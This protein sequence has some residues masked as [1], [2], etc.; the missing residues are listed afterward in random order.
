[1]TSITL[2]RPSPRKPQHKQWI[3]ADISRLDKPLL[4]VNIDTEEEFDWTKPF[5]RD[6]TSVRSVKYLHRAQ[7]I[8]KSYGVKPCYLIDYPI[9]A[10]PYA[11]EVLQLWADEGDCLVGAQLHPWVTPPHE[12]VVCPY[13]SYPCNLP[14][15]LERRKIRILTETIEASVGVRPTIYKA[16]RYGIKLK[17]I[18]A[19]A[20]EGYEVDTSVVPYKSYAGLGGG[21]DFFGYPDQPFWPDADETRVMCLP[22]TQSLVGVMR[23]A[24]RR[25]LGRVVFGRD[26]IKFRLPGLFSR[27]GLLERIMLSPEGVSVD[28]MR[29]LVDGMID[30]GKRVFALSFHSPS[31]QTG[32]TPYVRS[33]EELS[34]FL[35]RIEAMIDYILTDKG[36]APATPL[37]IKTVLS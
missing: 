34:E 26:G 3:A 37:E 17:R 13:N 28:A 30:D 18:W 31:L 22:V 10:D 12:E 20:E 25:G 24:G 16:G 11:C 4:C 1:M 23:D 36:G 33:E 19:L 27:L 14:S 21:P 2:Q 29:R 5:S 6:N 35:Y 9:A 7:T 15:D 8:F 32:R